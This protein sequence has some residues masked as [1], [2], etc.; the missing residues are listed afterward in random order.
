MRFLIRPAT[1]L[2]LEGLETSLLVIKSIYII[3]AAPSFLPGHV[4]MPYQAPGT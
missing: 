3:F 4:P 2:G 1:Y